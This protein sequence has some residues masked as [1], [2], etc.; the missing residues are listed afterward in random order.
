MFLKVLYF[1]ITALHHFV[2]NYSYITAAGYRQGTFIGLHHA[3]LLRSDVC[4]DN[5]RSRFNFT[6]YV[7]FDLEALL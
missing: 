3:V 2:Y 7:R 1:L 6:V 4:N 5:R